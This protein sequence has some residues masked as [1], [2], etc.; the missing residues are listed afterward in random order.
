MVLDTPLASLDDQTLQGLF[1]VLAGLAQMPDPVAVLAG[2][3][4]DAD[5][6]PGTSVDG[7]AQAAPGVAPSVPVG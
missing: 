7:F 1:Q 3:L 2:F 5:G 6:T 4:S